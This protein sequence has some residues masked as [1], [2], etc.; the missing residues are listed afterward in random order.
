MIDFEDRL[1]NHLAD[2]ARRIDVP[3]GRLPMGGRSSFWSGVAMV[4]VA[5]TLVV[6]ALLGFALFSNREDSLLEAPVTTIASE[7][8][9]DMAQTQQTVHPEPAQARVGLVDS[10]PGRGTVFA[11]HDPVMISAVPDP[12][13]SGCEGFPAE[14][15]RS[16]DLTDGE[17]AQVGDGSLTGTAISFGS[18]V[19]LVDQCE[20]SI[21]SIRTGEFTAEGDFVIESDTVDVGEDL[22]RSTI[23]P[24]HATA[25][26]MLVTDESI[27]HLDPATGEFDE[28]TPSPFPV[29]P[30]SVAAVGEYLVGATYQGHLEV[31]V[32]H[33]SGELV[34]SLS[35]CSVVSPD[36]VG[37]EAIASG[38]CGIYVIDS[39]GTPRLFFNEEVLTAEPLPASD[40]VLAFTLKNDGSAGDW[41]VI[42]PEGDTYPVPGSDQSPEIIVSQ[43]GALLAV[44][45]TSA[46]STRVVTT[47]SVT[48]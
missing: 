15:W 23:A 28:T 8:S 18:R 13:I 6:V 29:Q 36:F 14:T 38:A 27:A 37:E 21:A 12:D 5:A 44:P 26:L 25:K 41:R 47:E 16:F 32:Y 20:G 33:R 48:A 30:T 4:P 9:S 42:T 1:R 31:E 45:D 19:L 10:V 34:E 7:E 17:G 2:E 46:E 11:P 22:A 3:D 40:S 39:S 35:D 24:D 43:D